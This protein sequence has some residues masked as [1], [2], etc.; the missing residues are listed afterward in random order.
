MLSI[1]LKSSCYSQQASLAAMKWLLGNG[2]AL[3]GAG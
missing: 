1:N 2:S 3:E